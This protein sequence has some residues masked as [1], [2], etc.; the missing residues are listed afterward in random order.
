MGPA[1]VLGQDL[2]EASGAVRDSAATDLAAGNRKLGNGHRETAGT[3]L[4]HHLYDARPERPTWRAPRGNSPALD[5]EGSG[6]A[7]L[8]RRPVMR[9][10]HVIST[11]SQRHV[12]AFQGHDGLHKYPGH[13]RYR[14]VDASDG[15]NAH[16]VIGRQI[17]ARRP[18]D[19]YSPDVLV[20]ALNWDARRIVMFLVVD[21]SG[22]DA[23]LLPCLAGLVRLPVRGSCR[24]PTLRRGGGRVRRAR[25]LRCP[26][27]VRWLA[28][29]SAGLT[30][31]RRSGT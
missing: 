2:A 31:C 3:R 25:P 6:I 23:R 27:S 24:W 16:D 19:R 21:D 13:A 14:A 15:R 22:A 17:T 10:S 26:G 11:R 1:V 9:R 8:S 29:P 18:A 28:A 30:R 4:A 7:T 20:A 12:R 5:R